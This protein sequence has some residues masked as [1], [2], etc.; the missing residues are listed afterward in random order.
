VVNFNNEIMSFVFAS[1]YNYESNV[2]STNTVVSGIFLKIPSYHSGSEL[3][4]P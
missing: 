1:K 2:G 4:R 3:Q